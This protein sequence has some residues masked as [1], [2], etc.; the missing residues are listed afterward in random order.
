MPFTFFY[1]F[2]LFKIS[3]QSRQSRTLKRRAKRGGPGKAEPPQGA[4]FNFVI[5]SRFL[6][7]AGDLEHVNT[8]DHL[9]FFRPLCCSRFRVE[10]DHLEH[11]KAVRTG[12]GLGATLNFVICVQDFVAMEARLNT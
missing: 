5:S 3:C 8:R 10:A 7:E 4:N 2:V 9:R 12:V 11:L 1:T 6:C